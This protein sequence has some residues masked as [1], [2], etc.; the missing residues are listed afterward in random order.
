[1]RSRSGHQRRDPNGR[2]L[3][4]DRPSN[5]VHG[6]SLEIRSKYRSCVR[7]HAMPGLRKG[8]PGWIDHAL[9]RPDG[10]SSRVTGS[11]CCILAVINT[12]PGIGVT[13]AAATRARPPGTIDRNQ[14]A[15]LAA[16]WR[17]PRSSGHDRD[18]TVRLRDC[19]RNGDLLRGVVERR[20]TASRNRGHRRSCGSR[21]ILEVL[22]TRMV[23]SYIFREIGGV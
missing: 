17:R 18:M 5:G 1:M 19:M 6:S 11:P 16:R 2:R 12:Q 13:D 15:G 4:D 21:T 20:P 22:L 8:S 10:F 14:E 9:G 7:L 23:L 3:P